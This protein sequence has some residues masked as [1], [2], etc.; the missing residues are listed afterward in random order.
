MRALLQRA[1][2]ASV[3]IDGEPTASIGSGLVVLLGIARDDDEADAEYLV[4]KT[5][6]LR[7]FSDESGHFNR[8]VLDAGGELLVVSQFTLYAA[9][10]KGRR[11]DFT[12]AAPPK[13]AEPLYERTVELFR[14]TGLRVATGSFGALMTVS[15]HN[16]GPVTIMLDSA[17]RFRPR[18]GRGRR[19]RHSPFTNAF[20]YC[21][22]SIPGQASK[23]L[24]K[25]NIRLAPAFRITAT[26]N[27]SR[28]DKSLTAPSKALAERISAMPNGRTSSTIH[29]SSQRRRQWRRVA[30][31][32]CNGGVSPGR[33]PRL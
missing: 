32:P 11:P 12:A 16:H 10:R 31:W 18:E 28:E 29:P 25:L 30:V 17:D 6:N 24:S 23:P 21:R 20:R 14:E 7:I 26:C 15:I 22:R 13:Q 5:V 33:P 9:T 1:A 27:A 19:I 4:G 8:S 3:S 2:A